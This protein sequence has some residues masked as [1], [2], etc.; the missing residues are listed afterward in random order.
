MNIRR[1]LLAFAALV[2]L[3]T[4]ACSAEVPTVSGT[5]ENVSLERVSLR[6]KGMTCGTCPLAV[7]QA[8]TQVEGMISVEVS[9]EK[10]HADVRYDPELTDPDK[11]I[12]AVDAIGFTAS[13]S[14]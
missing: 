6:V 3:G 11:L 5:D 1:Y 8:L 12:A 14:E 4:G 2:V 13:P 10:E 9:Y 7:R